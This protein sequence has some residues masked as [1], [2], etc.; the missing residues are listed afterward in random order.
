M[1]PYTLNYYSSFCEK[2]FVLDNMSTDNSVSIC[3]NYH[4]VK[5][6]QWGSDGKLNDLKYIELKCNL[7][8][9]YSRQNYYNESSAA[10]WVICIDMDEFIHHPNLIGLLAY[11]DSIGVTVPDVKG[12]HMAAKSWPSAN[13]LLTKTIR[14]GVREP[15]FDKR[16]IFKPCID[17]KYSPG[18]HPKGSAHADLIND[19]KVVQSKEKEIALLHY[20]FIG[21]NFTDRATLFSQRLSEENK[22]R[23]FGIHYQ[24][25][26]DRL[27][28]IA[29]SMFHK[30]RE[31]IDES[32]SFVL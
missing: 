5:V 32:G 15:N 9:N 8:K 19:P 28:D 27:D 23:G 10:D 16:A 17:I 7:Y 31:I 25:G 11:Y 21:N 22:R 12:F 6:I 29:S 20:K 1:L 13:E 26:K 24:Q 14:T 18:C 3:S 30:S 2:I 4:N